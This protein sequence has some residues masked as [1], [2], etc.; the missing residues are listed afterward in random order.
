MTERWRE[1]LKEKMRSGLVR[2]EILIKERK[3]GWAGWWD[4]DC[5]RQKGKVKKVYKDWKESRRNN[6]YRRGK[7]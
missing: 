7:R 2:K 1:E 3:I 5:K 4:R 6:I